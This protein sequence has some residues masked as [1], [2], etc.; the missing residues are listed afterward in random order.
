MLGIKDEILYEDEEKETA[1]VM[2][3]TASNKEKF[4]K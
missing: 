1:S 2:C 4:K 3:I